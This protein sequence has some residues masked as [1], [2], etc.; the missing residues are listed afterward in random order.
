LTHIQRADATE[1]SAAQPTLHQGGEQ[2]HG[3]K[4]AL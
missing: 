3:I 4:S 2:L 1:I